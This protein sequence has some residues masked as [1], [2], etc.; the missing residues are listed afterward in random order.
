MSDLDERLVRYARHLD[1]RMDRFEVPAEVGPPVRRLE[2]RPGA[3]GAVSRSR[4]RAWLA[5]AAALCLL[6]AGSFAWWRST[7]GD[8]SGVADAPTGALRWEKT[9]GALGGWSVPVAAT[10]FRGGVLAVSGTGVFEP[11]SWWSPDGRTFE[12]QVAIEQGVGAPKAVA[13]DDSMAVAVGDGAGTAK[14]WVTTDATTWASGELRDAD[15]V[16]SVAST[17]VGFVVVGSSRVGP[18]GSPLDGAHP[19]AWSSS[20]GRTWARLAIADPGAGEL[21]D[22][23]AAPDAVVLVGAAGGSAYAQALDV[24]GGGDGPRTSRTLVPEGVASPQVLTDVAWVGDRFVAIGDGDGTTLWASTGDVG[25][26]PMSLGRLAGDPASTVPFT[27]VAGAGGTVVVVADA[28]PDAPTGSSSTWARAA[29]GEWEAVT[30]TDGFPVHLTWIGAGDGRL[31]GLTR[32]GE[33]WVAP[34]P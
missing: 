32:S 6:V 11:Y 12:S 5:T 25:F 8:L 15:S 22:V 4:H 2:A 10:A 17:P 23:A 1:E 30:P 27:D 21:L 20:D 14:S 19:A 9:E 18:D 13:A 34:L 28:G 16:R 24:H 29:G 3:D 26:T 7:S 31:L 33:L